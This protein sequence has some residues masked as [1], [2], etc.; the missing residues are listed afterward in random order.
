MA[1]LVVVVETVDEAEALTLRDDVEA[2]GGSATVEE[3]PGTALAPLLVVAV[4]GAAAVVARYLLQGD[5]RIVD[6]TGDAPVITTDKNLRANE[7][8]FVVRDGDGKATYRM[9]SAPESD[10]V[11]IINAG[12]KGAAEAV[13][14]AG[15]MQVV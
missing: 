11:S 5:G 13:V 12:V 7:I 6:L 8:L 14:G 9:E 1:D 10:L 4:V 3:R 2:A 15:G